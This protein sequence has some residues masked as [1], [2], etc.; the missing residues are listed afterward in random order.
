MHRLAYVVV[1]AEREREVA[2]TAAD[3]RS[4][5]VGADP[6]RSANEVERI[7]VVLAHAGSYGKHV[8]VEDDVERVHAHLLRE[9]TI[10]TLGYLDA[11][12]VCGSLSLLVETHHHD[13]GTVAHHVAGMTEEH[14]LAF[15]QRDRVDYRL[16]LHTLQSG[17]DNVPFGRVD[18]HRH[19][20]YVGL[21]GYYVKERAHLLAC[22]EQ[23]VVHVYVYHQG[24]VSHLLA[25][26]ADRL[27]V[28]LFVYKAQK[29]ARTCH[30]AA[31]AY[32][33]EAYVGRHV[34]QL[35]SAEPHGLR[36]RLRRVRQHAFYNLCILGYELLG[37]AAA[38]AYDVHQPLV[39]VLLHLR[40]HR[41]CRLVV[42]AHTV[43][44]TGVGICTNIIR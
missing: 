13:R 23:T 14:L 40:S 27:V 37:C 22:V 21:R 18:H 35:Q 4:G 32:V 33:D 1:A 29:L 39:H 38:A 3:M 11:S 36:L 9:Q 7:I 43:G 12:L 20:R 31:L 26:Y 6:L 28:I 24:S 19:L 10:C 34:E 25:C 16:A 44:Q 2:H 30:V 42:F 15:L 17:G 8:R 5:Q 41:L